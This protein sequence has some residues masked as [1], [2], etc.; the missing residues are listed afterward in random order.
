MGDPRTAEEVYALVRVRGVLKPR[1]VVKYWHVGPDSPGDRKVMIPADAENN[2]E[3]LLSEP[4]VD[5]LDFVR[6]LGEYIAEVPAVN[7]D[8]AFKADQI[9]VPAVSIAD[10]N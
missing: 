4:L 2:V 8:I 5:S 10:Y 9:L 7:K 6:I 3:F 1:G